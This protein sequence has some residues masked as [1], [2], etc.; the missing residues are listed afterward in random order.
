MSD[1]TAGIGGATLRHRYNDIDEVIIDLHH[2]GSDEAIEQEA[3]E[4]GEFE[5]CLN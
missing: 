4:D 5:T 1:V 3:A 2:S